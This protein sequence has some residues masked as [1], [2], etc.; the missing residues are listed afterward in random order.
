MANLI[1]FG[2]Q[3]GLNGTQ[4]VTIPITGLHKIGNWNIQL[5]TNQPV[6]NLHARTWDPSAY[7]IDIYSVKVIYGQ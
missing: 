3:N 7:N 6:T 5:D 2:G 4:T 1:D